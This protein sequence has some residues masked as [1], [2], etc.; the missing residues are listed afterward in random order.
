MSGFFAISRFI[1][2][3]EKGFENQ[4]N[5]RIQK[6]IFAL[7]GFWE[8]SRFSLLVWVTRCFSM[9]KK[10]NARLLN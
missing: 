5:Y 6:R 4:G 7:K 2:D 1:E 10:C 3:T 9:P 8:A